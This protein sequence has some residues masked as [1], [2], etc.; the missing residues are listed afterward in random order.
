MLSEMTVPE[1][2]EWVT[3]Y[4]KFGFSFM[5]A[6]RNA[7]MLLAADYNSKMMKPEETKPW[8]EFAPAYMSEAHD[9]AVASA[10][11]QMSDD[12]IFDLGPGVGGIRIERTNL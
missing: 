8:Y 10:Q 4:C 7:A 2:L 1:Y 5:N 6:D 12:E 11:K 9:R 3:Y